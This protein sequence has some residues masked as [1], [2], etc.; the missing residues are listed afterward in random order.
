VEAG[1][2]LELGPG[3]T[4]SAASTGFNGGTLPLD[5]Q[6]AGN[7][8]QLTSP[9]NAKPGQATLNLHAPEWAPACGTTVTALSAGWMLDSFGSVTADDG[10]PGTGTWL[11]EQTATTAGATLTCP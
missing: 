11:P 8:G 2:T 6:A 7:F 1:G 10:A 5:A 4:V 9:G 3:V